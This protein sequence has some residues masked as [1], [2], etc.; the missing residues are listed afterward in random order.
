[1][2]SVVE[3]CQCNGELYA[4][5]HKIHISDIVDFVPIGEIK[6]YYISNFDSDEDDFPENITGFPK[7]WKI[8]DE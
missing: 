4:E 6:E 8:E 1:M 2:T 7:R 3:V 5:D